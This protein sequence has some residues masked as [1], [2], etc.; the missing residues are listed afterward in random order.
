MS[1][2]RWKNYGPGTMTAVDMLQLGEVAPNAQHVALVEGRPLVALIITPHAHGRHGEVMPFLLTW[3]MAA[4]L[5]GQLD[6]WAGSLPTDVGDRYATVRRQVGEEAGKAL[7]DG[8]A[9]A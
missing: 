2:R 7:R 4:L 6:A 5:H 1:K 8:T 3:Q 9:S